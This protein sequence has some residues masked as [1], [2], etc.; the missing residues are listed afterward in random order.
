MN[1]LS[2]E[3][4]TFT[5]TPASAR[6]T[7]TEL[8]DGNIQV[9]VEVADGTIADLSGF[10]FNLADESLVDGLSV[11]GDDV[12]SSQFRRNR[13]NNLGSGVNMNGTKTGFDGGVKIGR[14]GIGEG[15]DFRETT[16]ILSHNSTD[17]TLDLFEN[18]DFGVR[19]LSVGEDREGSSKLVGV[20]DEAPKAV[21]DTVNTEEDTPITINVLA[22]DDQGEA[23]ATVSIE[24]G[25]EPVNGAVAVNPDGTLDYTPDPDFFGEDTFTYT[26]TDRDGDTSTANVTVIVDPN[27]EAVNDTVVTDEDVPI[28]I[29]VLSNDDI[30][31]ELDTTVTSVGDPSNGTVVINSD[32]TVTYSPNP[33][34]NGPDSFTYTITDDDGDTSTAT[35]AITVND[36]NDAPTSTPIDSQINVD[37]D[38]PSLDVS[39]NFADIDGTIA[40]YAVTGLPTGLSIDGSG[41]ISGTIDPNASDTDDDNNGTQDYTVTVTATDDD[42]ATTDQ[43]F[44]WTVSNVDPDAVD[45][46]YS[47]DEDNILTVVAA[48]GVLGN[49]ADGAPDS[50]SLT[51]VSNSTPNNGTVVVNGDG[52]FKYTP[53][54][55]F[56][57][58]DSFDYTVEDGNGGSDTA[59]VNITVNPVD[60]ASIDLNLIPD[61]M[62]ITDDGALANGNASGSSTDTEGS[63][64]LF[65]VMSSPGTLSYALELG[66]NTT[67]TLVDVETGETVS[68]SLNAGVVEGRTASSDV[69]VFTLSAD[70]ATG[71]VTQTQLRAVEHTVEEDA[72]PYNGDTTGLGVIDAV[73]L[74]G[75]VDAG[76]DI[77]TDSIDISSTI[78]FTDDGPVLDFGNLV[79]TGT[80]EPQTGFWGGAAGADGAADLTVNLTGY[81]INGEPGE[82]APSFTYTEVVDGNV[83]YAGFIKDDFDG[84]GDA[85]DA[86]NFDLIVNADG[87]YVIDLKEAFT[88]TTTVK[89]T[90][91]DGQAGGPIL[92]DTLIPAGGE[93]IVIFAVDHDATSTQVQSQLTLTAAEIN[94]NSTFDF[95]NPDKV[96]ASNQGIGVNNNIL[97]L[98]QGGN[99]VPES[100]VI[101]PVAL[102]D[103][104]SFG[105]TGTGNNEFKLGDQLTYKVFYE[106]GATEKV[107][108]APTTS[109]DIDLV[110]VDANPSLGLI[111]AVQL[112]MDAGEVKVGFIDIGIVTENVASPVSLRFSAV[113]TD[114][115]GDTTPAS[116]F[117]V[118]LLTGETLTGSAEPDALT[119]GLGS[120][121]LTGDGGADSFIYSSV[122]DG[123]DF[124]TDFLSGI[125][126]I[127]INNVAGSG[128]EGVSDGVLTSFWAVH[129]E[130]LLD[131]STTQMRR[132]SRTGMVLTNLI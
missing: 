28:V 10:F 94:D 47:V 112:I 74:T 59:T 84:D 21:S 119:G 6:I 77:A 68:L 73:K 117:S 99:A 85:D 109:T 61:A 40:S 71:A 35:V 36:V 32:G 111:D 116:F 62:L 34:Y 123:S 131:F 33:N 50:D 65:S 86:F 13:V 120:Q 81:T 64:T 103:S 38:M 57:G 12:T 5:G 87:T 96:N 53:N 92:A 2:F 113:L 97:E 90:G 67:T 27:P 63:G 98:P 100:I 95:L 104:V 43:T 93:E 108:I 115:D 29:D 89:V 60:D 37:G 102:V 69:L 25:D 45:D 110:T 15:D 4:S 26:I 124:I 70:S 42:G 52:S 107:T 125:D 11:T 30:A 24:S 76:G 118:D 83:T 78:K 16:F 9:F 128:F 23:S 122:N 49:D 54:A 130:E 106:G 51:V 18:Q 129:L 101:N 31:G 3:I 55:D 41:V 19:Y 1:S 121:T 75:T 8:S 126:R 22:N 79:G 17:L 46:A 72:A 66:A 39:G 114:D 91:G 132:S 88:S 7:L 48:N 14:A 80:A 82:A 105:L 56:N 20:S 44:T 127:V 58:S